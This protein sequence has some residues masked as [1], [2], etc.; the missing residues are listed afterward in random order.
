MWL[1]NMWNTWMWTSGFL[2]YV[3][4]WVIWFQNANVPIYAIDVLGDAIG[5]GSST[6]QGHPTGGTST[7]LLYNVN[8]LK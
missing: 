5:I 1:C 6:A 2:K 4:W 8:V 3:W 7:F